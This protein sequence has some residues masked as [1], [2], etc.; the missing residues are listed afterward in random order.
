MRPDDHA[1]TPGQVTFI[2]GVYNYCDRWCERC[3]FQTRCR[4]YRDTRRM[5]EFMEGRLDKADLEALQSD[6]EFEEDTN[7]PPVSARERAEFLEGLAEANQEPSPEESAR[8]ERAYE[9]HTRQLDAHPLTRDAMEYAT[10]SRRLVQIL[11]SAFH[12]GGDPLA[13]ESLETIGRF[14]LM[15]AV[16]TRRAAAG[17]LPLC[18]ELGDDEEFRQSDANGCAKL[19]RLMIAESRQAWELLVHLPAVTADGVPAAMVRRLDTLDARLAAEFPR[20]M[21]FVRMG[22]DEG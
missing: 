6:E 22:L 7:A 10:T 3:R 18:E 4:L 5:E 19:V 14:G 16:K 8:I 2:A 21:S 15:I 13:A 20:A 17:L 12:A 11:E 9:R 1:G